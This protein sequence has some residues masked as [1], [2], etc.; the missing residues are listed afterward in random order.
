MRVGGL[1]RWGGLMPSRR[2]ALLLS[3]HLTLRDS[4]GVDPAG[5]TNADGVDYPDIPSFRRGRCPGQG[6]YCSRGKTLT[7]AD[8]HR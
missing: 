4:R 6:G 1:P 8:G 3:A 5:I 7:F 2:W